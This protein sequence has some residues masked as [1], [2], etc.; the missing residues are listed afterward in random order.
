MEYSI[1]VVALVSMS[2]EE[3][4]LRLN[5]ICG[6]ALTA[7]RIEIRQRSSHCGR[8]HPQPD[9]QAHGIAPVVHPLADLFRKILVQEEVWKVGIPFEGLPD[10]VKKHGADDAAPF[11]DPGHLAQPHAVVELARCAAQQ[12]ESLGI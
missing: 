11:P 3:I 10:P 12:I 4:P 1:T 2:A 5:E 6:Q 8:R 9:R 7:E